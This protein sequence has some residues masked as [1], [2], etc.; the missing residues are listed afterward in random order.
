MREIIPRLLTKQGILSVVL[1]NVLLRQDIAN[2]RAEKAKHLSIIDLLGRNEAS[3]ETDSTGVIVSINR[4]LLELSGYAENELIGKNMSV[5]HSGVHDQ[6]FWKD[7]W[8]TIS[9]GHVWE[10]NV[11]EKGKDGN[12]FW[13]HTVVSPVM[14]NDKVVSYQVASYDIT[15]LEKLRHLRSD[16]P[17]ARTNLQT[18]LPNRAQLIEDIS[19]RTYPTLAVV[20]V[21]HMI[22]VNNA[23]GPETGDNVLIAVG[24]RL[25]HLFRSKGGE[26]YKLE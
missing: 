26:A 21:N 8:S 9:T 24:G 5:F 19:I 23:Y 22:E 18:G 14:E 3:I 13:L 20:H 2:L 11:C 17:D 6:G 10:G 4:R 1:E 15:E 25:S 7:F 16:P 12:L